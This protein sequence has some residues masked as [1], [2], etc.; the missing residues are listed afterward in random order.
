MFSSINPF[1]A[2]VYQ[3][4]QGSWIPRRKAAEK[5]IQGSSLVQF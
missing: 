2:C 3:R 1:C 5:L 4:I